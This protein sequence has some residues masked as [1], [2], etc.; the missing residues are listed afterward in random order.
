MN[1]NIMQN[2]ENKKYK[3]VKVSKTEFELDNGDILPDSV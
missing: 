2:L 3:V 1:K